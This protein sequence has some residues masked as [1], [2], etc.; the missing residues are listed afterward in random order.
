ML[1]PCLPTRTD[2]LGPIPGRVGA[3]YTLH[4]QML[5]LVGGTPLKLFDSSLQYLNSHLAE[6]RDIP[7]P[8]E[9]F[10]LD[11]LT[12]SWTKLF[13]KN[14]GPSPRIHH[15]V[16]SAYDHIYL[17]GGLSFSLETQ[18]YEILNDI[19]LFSLQTHRWQLLGYTGSRNHYSCTLHTIDDVSSVL[20]SYDRRLH[21]ALVISEGVGPKDSFFLLLFDLKDNSVLDTSHLEPNA[22]GRRFVNA[23]PIR[24]GFSQ[25]DAI[26][27]HT[28]T[29]NALHLDIFSH[30]NK[31]KQF[32][33]HL[34]ITNPALL[35]ELHSLPNIR[36]SPMLD[37]SVFVVGGGYTPKYPLK[38]LICNATS[39]KYSVL[40]LKCSSHKPEVHDFCTGLLWKDHRKVVLV[41]REHHMVV[42]LDISVAS[43]LKFARRARAVVRYRRGSNEGG[44]NSEV[45]GGT[46]ACMECQNTSKRNQ[47]LSEWVNSETNQ[48]DLDSN[49]QAVFRRQLLADENIPEDVLERV[50]G[51]TDQPAILSDFIDDPDAAQAKANFSSYIQYLVPEAKSNVTP[52]VLDFPAVALGRNV[53]QRYLNPRNPVLSDF[54]LLLADNEFV[55]VPLVVLQRRWGHY[56]ELIFAEA[57]LLNASIARNKVQQ[58]GGQ[59]SVSADSSRKGSLLISLLES[60]SSKKTRKLVQKS[61]KRQSEGPAHFSEF[62]NVPGLRKGSVVS[63]SSSVSNTLDLLLS[64]RLA[65][66]RSLEVLSLL[67]SI[68]SVAD[69]GHVLMSN[70][71]LESEIVLPPQPP[72]PSFEPPQPPADKAK[73]TEHIVFKYND[74]MIY[75][76]E[77][78]YALEDSVVAPDSVIEPEP[79][80]TPRCLY[81]PYPTSTVRALAEFFLTAQLNGKTSVDDA[82]ELYGVLQECEIP[83][84]RG[85]TLEVMEGIV[86]KKEKSVGRYVDFM[87]TELSRILHETPSDSLKAGGIQSLLDKIRQ[88]FAEFRR[89]MALEDYGEYLRDVERKMQDDVICN[90]DPQEFEF[91]G[92][93]LGGPFAVTIDDLGSTAPSLRQVKAVYEMT[94]TH[95]EMELTAKTWHVLRASQTALELKTPAELYIK[96]NLIS[97]VNEET[98]NIEEERKA[99]RARK[100][101]MEDREHAIKRAEKQ[102]L[103]EIEDL[104]VEK[105]RKKEEIRLKK[106][107]LRQI[108]LEQ[109]R[110]LL[111]A[112]LVQTGVSG[113][114]IDSGASKKPTSEIVDPDLK[115]KMLDLESKV[116]LTSLVSANSVNSAGGSI[117]DEKGGKTK[118][119]KRFLLDKFAS[120]LLHR[121]EETTV[122]HSA[123]FASPRRTGSF[124]DITRKD[125]LQSLDRWTSNNLDKSK[126]STKSEKHNHHH[127]H[128]PRKLKGFGL[129]KTYKS[130]LNLYAMNTEP[131]STGASFTSEYSDPNIT[132]RKA[133][134]HHHRF[135]LFH[136]DITAKHSG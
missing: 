130:S 18:K 47:Q 45:S 76:D 82:I 73:K 58:E 26:C 120:D 64:S 55:H 104:R 119:K 136:H 20:L 129:E 67:R 17:Y 31:G 80:L 38:A 122:K 116:S 126:Q 41:E 111:E 7:M 5:Y 9:I 107:H 21:T 84:L 121:H 48:I 23:F 102:K 14:G 133:H 16:T 74:K 86:A 72:M 114:S 63:A 132:G 75:K 79:M 37:Y 89:L 13:T 70:T 124:E 95:L 101:A 6:T 27:V 4:D 88:D 56:F 40:E 33:R 109:Q 108:L 90:S 12:N 94:A 51:E 59:E 127:P 131:Q 34:D 99:E 103:L 128:L 29:E 11:L 35:K 22:K 60:S 85:V 42:F 2:P 78:G 69:R 91:K 1:S 49:L 30:H 15:A 134:R 66:G 43:A 115:E 71:L 62:I 39:R 24:P 8:V 97:K 54:A 10:Q 123:T 77:E 92:Q 3:A 83:L 125:T 32:H 105:E 96:A 117:Q 65:L 81:M 135:N 87:E 112:T 93:D 36:L 52:A 118:K 98:A 53:F 28:L 57:C 44:A 61:Q 68:Q 110:R 46:E 19:W 113:G 100:R 106:Q 50:V 25:H